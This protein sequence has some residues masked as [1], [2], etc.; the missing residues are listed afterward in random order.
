MFYRRTPLDKFS[1]LDDHPHPIP[2][3]NFQNKLWYPLDL[4]FGATETEKKYDNTTILDGRYSSFIS[5]K[6]DEFL[7][8]TFHITHPSQ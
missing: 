1:D 4:W 7:Y 6:S 5:Q 8:E 2:T 3:Q